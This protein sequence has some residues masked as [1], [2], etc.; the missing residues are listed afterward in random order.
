MDLQLFPNRCSTENSADFLEQALALEFCMLIL[1]F[2]G[3]SAL[4]LGS[5]STWLPTQ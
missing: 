4:G 3:G 2:F 1:V 5:G